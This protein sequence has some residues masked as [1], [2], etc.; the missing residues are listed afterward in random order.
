MGLHPDLFQNV[1]AQAL[2][3][4]IGFLIQRLDVLEDPRLERGAFSSGGGCPGQRV[5]KAA[6][7]AI[8]ARRIGIQHRH[9]D[10]L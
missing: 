8:G 9:A 4:S 1:D 2:I 5:T 3:A 7:T 10:F 6:A